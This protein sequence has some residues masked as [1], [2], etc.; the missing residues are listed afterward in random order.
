MQKRS[1]SMEGIRLVCM[2]EIILS[3]VIQLTEFGY[4]DEIHANPSMR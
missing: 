3:N 4:I 2:H 1:L